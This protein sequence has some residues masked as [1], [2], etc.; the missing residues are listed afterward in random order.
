MN[1]VILVSLRTDI[2]EEMQD[3]E[4]LEFV[5]SYRDC[6]IYAKAVCF[7]TQY[8]AFRMG[9]YEVI[10]RELKLQKVMD[11]IDNLYTE[12]ITTCGS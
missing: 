3:M 1:Q 10:T 9:S 8:I 7:G 4:L 12:I 6:E 2:R 5:G 11:D